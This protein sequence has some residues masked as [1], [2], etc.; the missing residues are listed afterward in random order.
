MNGSNQPDWWDKNRQLKRGL[1]IPDYEP[2]RFDD[3]TY[4][5]S[6]VDELEKVFGCEIRFVGYNT[7]YPDDWVV[8]VDGRKIMAIGRYRDEN[9]NTVYKL[10]SDEF[11]RQLEPLLEEEYNY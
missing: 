3:G 7:E 2:P 9:G 11:K 10:T 1:G 8:E 6:V 5:H 4:T